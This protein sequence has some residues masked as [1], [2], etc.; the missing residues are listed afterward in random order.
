MPKSSPLSDELDA[1]LGEVVDALRQTLERGGCATIVTAPPG[2][3]G[4]VFVVGAK[5]ATER[6]AGVA[7]MTKAC[8]ALA[9]GAQ[10]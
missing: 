1:D 10:P 6:I 2:G 3:D 4:Q 5:A 7:M 8:S 9:A